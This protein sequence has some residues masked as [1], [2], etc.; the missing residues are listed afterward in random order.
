M[1]YTHITHLLLFRKS[2]HLFNILQVYQ[3]SL[4]N[5]RNEIVYSENLSLPRFL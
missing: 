2:S 3:L 4:P 1:V 5:C